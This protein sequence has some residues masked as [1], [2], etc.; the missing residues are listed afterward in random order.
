M[1]ASSR[2]ACHGNGDGDV[3]AST[4]AVPI[5]SPSPDALALWFPRKIPTG[6]ER[7]YFFMGSTRDP[8]Y[9]WRWQSVGSVE[10]MKGTGPGKLAAL[11]S[12]S[13]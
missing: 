4:S 13:W 3:K 2:C 9:A 8:V 1:V 7:P 6:M 5:P 10:E 11:F 12:R